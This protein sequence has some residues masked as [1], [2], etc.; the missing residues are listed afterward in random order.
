MGGWGTSCSGNN[1]GCR[2]DAN[3]SSAFPSGLRVGDLAGPDGASNGFTALWTSSAAVETY[4]PDGST[5]GALTADLVDPGTTPAGNLASQLVAVK[6]S[7][8]IAALPPS[9][10]LVACGD[11]D[12]HGLTVAQLAAL[13]DAAVATGSLPSGVSFTSLASTLAAV[14][15]NFDNCTRNDGC[16][17]F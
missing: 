15:L 14:N 6:L 5:S 4:L 8:A 1:A 7:L 11:E 9:L 13:G 2:R 16:L 10:R 17:A 12:L 3:F